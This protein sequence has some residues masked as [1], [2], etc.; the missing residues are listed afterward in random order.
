[1][2]YRNLDSGDVLPASWTDAIQ[3]FV[4][5]L[6]TNLRLR[7]Q[8]ANVVEA[9]A[10]SG[11]AQAS[12]G[13][14]GLWRYRTTTATATVS[15]SAGTKDIYVVASANS[16]ATTPDPDTD[17]TDYNWYLQVLGSGVTPTGNTP[18]GNP[19]TAYTKV[20]ELRWDGTTTVTWLRQT[21]GAQ[22][23]TLPV[24]PLASQPGQVPLQ[25]VGA[26]AQTAPLLAARIGLAG[27]DV[28]TVGADGAITS[29]VGV[30]AGSVLSAGTFVDSP[31]YRVSGTALAASHLS[32]G[33]TG[34]G[35]VVLAGSPA[36][37]G[38]PT[39]PTAVTAS[40]DTTIA[41]T[42]LVAAKIT[43]ALGGGGGSSFA[44][45]SLTGTGKTTLMFPDTTTT[46]GITWGSDTTLY[47]S[48]ADTLKTDD[49]LIVGTNL[50]VLGTTAFTGAPTGPTAAA[51]T[52]T[53]QLA[54]TAFVVA[55]ASS[56]NP[57]MDGTVAIGTS[58]RYARADHVHASDTS[59][60]PLASPALTGTPTSTTASVDTNTTQIATTAFVV[61]QGYSKL[62]SPTFTG[63]P[64]APTAAPGTSTTQLA[65][66]AFVTTADNLKANLASP[67]FTGTP[68]APTAAVDTNTTQLATTAFVLGQASGSN[69][70][71][72]GTVAQ[73]TSTRYARQD[74]VHPTDTS[75]A[76]IAS[77][78]FTGTV[79]TGP[80]TMNG[81]SGSANLAITL[82]G[83]ALVRIRN[84]TPAT[85][86]FADGVGGSMDTTLYRQGAGVLQTP[87]TMAA[88]SF[89][90]QPTAVTGAA[91]GFIM[92]SGGDAWQRWQVLDNGVMQFGSGAVAPD[93]SLSRQSA[94]VMQVGT[95]AVVV[96]N[97][98]RL[99]LYVVSS[100]QVRDTGESGQVRAGRV[101]T[102][103][104][105]VDTP[106]LAIY[107]LGST[108]DVSGSGFTLT[109]KG[110]VT[111]GSGVTGAATEAAIFTGSTSQALYL[112]TG[113][114]GEIA[115]RIR[116]G[117]WGCWF[118]TAKRG[119]A[120]YMMGKWGTVSQAA[121]LIGV[122]AANAIVA[123]HSTNGSASE[124]VTCSTDVADDRWH[125]VVV[126]H[127]ASRL[128]VYV[129]G[130]LDGSAAV[131]TPIFAGTSPFNIGGYAADASTATTGPFFGRIDEAFV[132]PE[133]LTEERVRHLY[134]ASLAHTLG[135]YPN[136]AVVNV[137]R[138]QRGT[139]FLQSDFP[140][141]ASAVRIY[142][143]EAGGASPADDGSNGSALGASGGTI[144]PVS[145][146]DGRSQ[147][148]FATNASAYYYNGTGSHQGTDTGLPGTTTS[149]S[150]GAWF[151]T[152]SLAGVTVMSW[153][154]TV[155]GTGDTRLNVNSS[156]SAVAANGADSATGT[157]VA[158]GTWH[159]GVVVEDNAAI[160]GIKRKL[161]I[162]GRCVA[163]STTLNS[164]T[165]SGVN[166]FHV[167]ANNDNTQIFVGSISR[168]F[169][170]SGALTPEQV[171][172][173]YNKGAVSYLYSPKNAGDHVE[174]ADNA[175]VLVNFDTLN[176]SDVVNIQ[177]AA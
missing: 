35:A 47:R 169:V 80:L 155:S 15:G 44:S 54:T 60:A 176:G 121:Y 24:S 156:G 165:L 139:S 147:Y 103:T 52:S 39:A 137:Q 102:T 88:K 98:T 96:S 4:G 140:T 94:G 19:I 170:Y 116:T 109:N 40:N 23:A 26:T 115:L 61:G 144:V 66:T 110:T 3:E 171:H 18:L 41:T 95:Q 138:V 152:T 143:A 37:T 30:A 14:G 17:N 22:D 29:A 70:L 31:A 106:A 57:V 2:K 133:V 158:D 122:T 42:A 92:G 55:Q 12:V 73:G 120:Q 123:F 79:T 127:D 21:Y 142:N 1:M 108:A 6:A 101:L 177:V 107:N 161:Y 7:L 53:T 16:F 71:M 63:T 36:L 159:F 8:A 87:G 174:H 164:I 34:T 157:Y 104:D 132:T 65:T 125:F 69:P 84:A 58:L 146:P 59:R 83:N 76:P 91:V 151:K 28:F 77:P 119:L 149:R 112:A 45:L 5:T 136:G 150:F 93:T 74:H 56:T 130:A 128:R 113:S 162:D 85:L 131:T 51:D 75:R 64:A 25:V 168:A 68:A 167:G 126:T 173:L 62:A 111:F 134:A 82:S 145:G 81:T 163:N 148:G 118:R 97:D 50:S 141:P 43:A 38:T 129:D 20:G 90:A 175:R 67:T 72:D 78:T 124:S 46:T 135:Q 99:P 27:T 117:S 153:G 11:S 154:G 86:E 32:N 105:F 10:S 89:S 160:D 100:R 49:S 48:A 9:A 114:G 166:R 13:P 172:K 33:T